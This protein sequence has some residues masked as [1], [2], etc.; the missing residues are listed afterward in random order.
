MAKIKQPSPSSL[1]LILITLLILTTTSTEA[2]SPLTPKPHIL[3]SL[4]IQTPNPQIQGRSC[5]YTVRIKT[6]CS[7]TRYTRDKI[8]IAFGDA[9]SH[10]VYVPGLEDPRSGAFES[11]ST[12][13]YQLSGPCL[14]R[15]CYLYLVRVGYDGW[16]PEY[17]T[18]SG[19]Y[20]P[21]VTFYYNTNLPY[22]V[23]FGFNYCNGMSMISAM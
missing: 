19:Y 2:K 1:F 21:A 18:I 23:W 9:Y 5:S 10:Q 6:S 16:M 14:S 11:C 8:S 13:T 3:E 7:S 22:G 17:V 15:V 4:E 20:T 12:D